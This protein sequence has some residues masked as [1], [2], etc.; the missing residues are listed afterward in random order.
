MAKPGPE[1]GSEGARRIAEAHRGPHEHDQLGGFA[2]KPDL[3]REA[4]RKGGETVKSRYGQTFYQSIGKKGG[5]TVKR[6]R[7]PEFYA[8]IGRKGGEMRGQRA[9]E[10]RA[11]KANSSGAS[12][13]APRKRGRPAKNSS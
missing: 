10:R 3:A 8:E 9:A 13:P 7:G 5:E 2:A 6:E 1:P 11:S 4:G 12:Q